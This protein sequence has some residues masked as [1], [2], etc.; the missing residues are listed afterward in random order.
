LQQDQGKKEL[1]LPTTPCGD[2]AKRAGSS[3]SLASGVGLW[4]CVAI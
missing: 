3:R 2:L 1:T 4:P